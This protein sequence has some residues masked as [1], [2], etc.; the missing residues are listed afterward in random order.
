MR[1][2]AGVYIYMDMDIGTWHAWS[3]HAQIMHAPHSIASTQLSS[4]SFCL[5]AQ[6]LISRF[7]FASEKN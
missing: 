2:H 4:S 7:S 5:P 3:A 6:Y 1:A